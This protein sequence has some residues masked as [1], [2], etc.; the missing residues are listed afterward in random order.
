MPGI[1]LICYDTNKS[2]IKYLNY[3]EI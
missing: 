1:D 3:K 2:F